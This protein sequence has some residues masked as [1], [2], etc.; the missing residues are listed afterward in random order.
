MATRILICV[1]D[2][3]LGHATRSIPVINA[4]RNSGCDVLIASSGHALK[5]LK[6]EFPGEE[7]LELPGYDPQYSSREGMVRKMIMQIPKFFRVIRKEHRLV[8]EL[9]KKRNIN[10]VV[11][12]NRYGCWGRAAL[13]VFITHQSNILMPKRFGW[14]GPIVRRVNER[15]M[16]RFSECWI[17]DDENGGNA[18][19]L[20]SF[21]DL[22]YKGTVKHIGTLSRFSKPEGERTKWNQILAVCSGPEP[23]RSTLETLLLKELRQS[24]KRSILVRGVIEPGAPVFTDSGV[25]FNYMT[26]DE[27][28][29]T[30]T[31]SEVIISRSGYSTVMDLKVVGGKAIFIPTPGQTEQEYLALRLKETGVAYAVSQDEFSLPVALNETEKYSGFKAERM[32]DRLNP[33]VESLLSSVANE[34]QD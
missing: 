20:T 1:L 19:E 6:V 17:P 26:S 25:V 27:L 15:M 18:G 9:V 16:N 4:F 30:V 7:C 21:E 3:G 34:S 28:K 22:R 33:A 10:V 8:E 5:L 23:Q 13:S 14:A 31:S 11:S 24:G 32:E 12:D 2:W 29:Q